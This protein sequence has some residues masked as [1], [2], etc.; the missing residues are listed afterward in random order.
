MRRSEELQSNV[1]QPEYIVFIED[2]YPEKLR[3]LA[4]RNSGYRLA[5]RHHFVEPLG[6]KAEFQF[7]NPPV[8]QRIAKN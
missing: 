4:L 7:V 2:L 1:H 8:F 5:A 3:K 6:L